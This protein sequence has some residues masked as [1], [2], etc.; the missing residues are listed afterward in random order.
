MIYNII[1][2]RW[3]YLAGVFI[4]AGL[5][6]SCDK[7]D[8]EVNSGKVELL[9]FGPTGANPGDT[10]RF[11]GSNLQKVTA[12]QFTG[13]AAATVE[14]KDF[15]TQTSELILLLLPAAGKSRKAR[16]ASNGR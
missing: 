14:Q 16:S 8:D 6:S 10:V 13:E 12:I 1:K 4:C 5:I 9:S 7:N 3:L 11:F 15:K 2:A